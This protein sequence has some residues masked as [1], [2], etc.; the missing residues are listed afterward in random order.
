MNR[1]AFSLIDTLVAAAILSII[2][3]TLYYA[4][5]KGLEVWRRAEQKLVVHEAA[6]AAISEISKTLASA[7]AVEGKDAFYG[8][9]QKLIFTAIIGG[10]L[11]EVEF[12]V[13]GHTFS[14][15]YSDCD[16]N[17]NTQPAAA[18]NDDEFLYWGPDTTYW[19]SGTG[20]PA[21]TCWTEDG[22]ASG[23]PSEDLPRAVMVS[24]TVIYMDERE[25][26]ETIV[27]LRNSE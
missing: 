14:S 25:G 7:I 2:A 22:T 9:P 1:K 19:H 17:F 10:E 12:D 11:K 21:E 18:S 13:Q 27:Y 8:Q 5:T 24:F 4:F 26:F 15:S 6:R 3:T 23:A 16:F 20:I